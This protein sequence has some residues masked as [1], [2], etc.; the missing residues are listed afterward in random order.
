MS[1]GLI[2]KD[3]RKFK[4]LAANHDDILI[5][6]LIAKNGALLSEAETVDAGKELVRE[7][8]TNVG[9]QLFVFLPWTSSE[10]EC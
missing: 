9:S 10:S 8:I 4:N 2:A 7:D 3:R 1:L 5:F 6:M